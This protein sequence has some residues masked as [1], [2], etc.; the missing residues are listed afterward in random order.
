MGTITMTSRK[1]RRAKLN[2]LRSLI[3]ELP[4]SSPL[5]HPQATNWDERATRY[6]SLHFAATIDLSLVRHTGHDEQG[7]PIVHFIFGEQL[8]YTTRW[9]KMDRLER[10]AKPAVLPEEVAFTPL[11]ANLMASRGE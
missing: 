10:P 2:E 4:S 3:N 8:F 9:P 7:R 1:E 6:N 5:V 11:R